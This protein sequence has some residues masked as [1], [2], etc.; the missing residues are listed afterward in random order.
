MKKKVLVLGA[1]GNI[2]PFLTPGLESHYDLTL[3]DI[4]AHPDGKEVSEVDVSSFEQVREAARGMDAI[5]NITVLR[6]HPERSFQVNTRGAWNV[7]KAAA[8][9][10]IKKVVH[11][12]PQYIR[13]AYDHEFDIA[14]V[15]RA[16]GTGYYCL[17]KML[18]S[19][20]CD[21]YARIYQIHTVCFVFNGLAARPTQIAEAGDFPP[22]TLI[23]EDL[24]LACRLAIDIDAV[25]DYY[26]EFNMLSYEGHGKYNVDKARRIL[27]FE[28]SEKWERYYARTP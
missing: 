11:T 26:Q 25:P 21:I 18:G 22:F 7:M 14:D 3:T 6:D 12:A 20:I 1:C 23:W 9:L 27:G 28:P 13:R 16:T 24:H 10:G 15:P 19:E 8:E 4:K 2:G 5:V 17:T